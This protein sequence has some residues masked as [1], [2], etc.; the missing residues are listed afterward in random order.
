MFIGGQIDELFM[1]NVED[2]E[3]PLGFIVK[4]DSFGLNVAYMTNEEQIMSSTTSTFGY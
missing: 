1:C 4:A 2:M 3:M